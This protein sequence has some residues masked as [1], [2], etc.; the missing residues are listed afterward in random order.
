MWSRGRSKAT[1][2][3]LKSLSKV[4]ALVKRRVARPLRRDRTRL[5]E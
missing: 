3:P 4:L 5:D 2:N 1:D